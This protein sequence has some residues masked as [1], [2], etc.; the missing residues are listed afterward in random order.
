MEIF[1]HITSHHITSEHQAY[2]LADILKQ[3]MGSPPYKV[4]VFFTTARL[5]GYFAELMNALGIA[6][7]EIHSR[8]SQVLYCTTYAHCLR[9]VLVTCSV[10][11]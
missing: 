5:T 8:K 6:T 10:L 11:T 7:L 2:V 1:Y 9:T 4:I 3:Q